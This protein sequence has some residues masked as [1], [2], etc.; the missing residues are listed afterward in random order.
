MKENVRS[1]V[2]LV[3][4]CLHCVLVFNSFIIKGFFLSALCWTLSCNGGINW[5]A[6][7]SAYNY[8]LSP[9]HYFTHLHTYTRRCTH[10]LLCRQWVWTCTVFICPD[11]NACSQTQFLKHVCLVLR[12]LRSIL[13]EHFWC[14]S[15]QFNDFSTL[16][17]FVITHFDCR[18][19]LI[20]LDLHLLSTLLAAADKYS[21]WINLTTIQWSPLMQ[22]R[23]WMYCG[24]PIIHTVSCWS[25]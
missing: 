23:R 24:F 15:P 8:V 14:N 21:L 25:C 12:G 18:L 10:T 11:T 4:C 9:A 6:E 1:S 22:L 13:L 17:S 7:I 5:S 3:C 16:S 2:W 19:K 20:K